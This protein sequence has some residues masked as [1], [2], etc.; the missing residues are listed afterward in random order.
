MTFG[1]KTQT[2]NEQIF[3]FLFSAYYRQ[4]CMYAFNFVHD[5]EIAKEL[6]QDVYI[7][8]WEKALPEENQQALKSFL[9]TSVRNAAI[10]Q[11]RHS[12]THSLYEQKI[13]ASVSEQYSIFDEIIIDDLEE[14]IE[15]VICRLPPQCQ[16]IFRMNRMENKKYKEIADE[17]QI[18]LKAVE[19]QISKALN[20]L[21]A[22]LENLWDN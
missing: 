10:D 20:L 3:D 6:V 12:K 18:S 11:L 17:L 22:A 4:L 8:L 9:Y 1:K 14:K 15:S 2:P 19:A 13:L 21:K 5:I 16:K 7:Q